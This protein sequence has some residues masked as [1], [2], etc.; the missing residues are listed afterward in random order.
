MEMYDLRLRN[1]YLRSS[2]SCAIFRCF[3]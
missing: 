1:H 2:I 3:I